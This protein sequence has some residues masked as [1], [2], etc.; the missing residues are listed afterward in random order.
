MT[1]GA[2]NIWDVRLDKKNI[3]QYFKI[4][5]KLLPKCEGIEKRKGCFFNAYY[6]NFPLKDFSCKQKD[7]G[8]H[9]NSII[10]SHSIIRSYIHSPLFEKPTATHLVLIQ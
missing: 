8:F 4:M 3:I 6:S 5:K 7:L 2:F 1:C 9:N 10:E